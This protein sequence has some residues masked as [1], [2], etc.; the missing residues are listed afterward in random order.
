MICSN[1]HSCSHVNG[2]KVFKAN[3]QMKGAGRY[4]IKSLNPNSR[5]ILWAMVFLMV[6]SSFSTTSML[7]D[8]LK[9]YCKFC[10]IPFEDNERS[11]GRDSDQGEESEKMK[12]F[13]PSERNL[14]IAIDLLKN[15]KSDDWLEIVKLEIRLSAIF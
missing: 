10:E 9:Q 6:S 15:Q 5:M 8:D 1:M 13:Q 14:R 7:A 4:Y 11:Q 3:R 12:E 2:E